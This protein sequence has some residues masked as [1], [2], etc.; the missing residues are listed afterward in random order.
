MAAYLNRR[1]VKKSGN[2]YKS[3]PRSCTSQ[4]FFDQLIQFLPLTY[5][6]Y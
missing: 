4:N 1:N 5:K 2:Q 6:S 3:R